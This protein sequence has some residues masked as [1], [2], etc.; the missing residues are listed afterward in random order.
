MGANQF[1]ISN[2]METKIAITAFFALAQETR[3]S[4][5]RLLVKAGPAGLAAGT[6]AD[7]LDLPGATLSFH[8]S[9]LLRAGLI[10]QERRSRSLV[11]SVR[12][13]TV[14][15]LLKFLMEDCCQGLI[16]AD[17]IAGDCCSP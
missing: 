2:I 4:I 15:D 11:Y 16:P 7:A 1:Y 14:Q 8:L 10:H 13:E 17:A 3:L 5:F 6:I 9:Q 12:F